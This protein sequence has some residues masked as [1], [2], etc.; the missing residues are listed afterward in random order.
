MYL[1]FAEPSGVLTKTVHGDI[2]HDCANPEAG[3]YE[4]CERCGRHHRQPNCFQ[5]PDAP[6]TRPV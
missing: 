2:R 3:G 6:R 4:R 5:Y 1:A